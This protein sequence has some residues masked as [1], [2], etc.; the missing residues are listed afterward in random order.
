MNE[1]AM[2]MLS[3]PNYELSKDFFIEICQYLHGLLEKC[4]YYEPTCL[5]F[6]ISS[7]SSVLIFA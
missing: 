5:S 4:H 7:T 2:V 1:V 3:L 6:E